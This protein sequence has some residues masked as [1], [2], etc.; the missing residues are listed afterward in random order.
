MSGYTPDG[1]GAVCTDYP[2]AKFHVKARWA[3][4]TSMNHI[5]E[6]QIARVFNSGMLAFGAF[7][8]GEMV[9]RYHSPGAWMD[10]TVVPR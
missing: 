5:A 9:W 4:G 10:F 2:V 8:S 6:A 1:I 3:D 7:V